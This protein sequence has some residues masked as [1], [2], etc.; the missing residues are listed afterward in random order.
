MKLIGICGG[1]GFVLGS[2]GG[3]WLTQYQDRQT[4]LHYGYCLCIPPPPPA[5]DH[6]WITAAFY[7]VLLG[8]VGLMIGNG[9]AKKFPPQRNRP[10]AASEET[11]GVWPPA[12]KS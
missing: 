8:G 11:M 6:L 2:S 5:P 1:I 3:Y 10:A 4:L 7:A 9:I 12:P